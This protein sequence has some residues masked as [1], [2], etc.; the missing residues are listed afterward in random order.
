M[1]HNPNHVTGRCGTALF[2]LCLNL[3][4]ASL[5]MADDGQEPITRQHFQELDIEIQVLKKEVLKVNRDLQVLEEELL[6]PHGQQLEVFVSMVNDTS[7]MLKDVRLQLDGQPVVAHT[8][9]RGEEAALHEGGVHRLYVGGIREGQHTLKVVIAGTDPQGADFSRQESKTI[10]KM[11][12]TRYI[13]LR[14]HADPDGR[15][16][17]VSILEW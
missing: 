14:L 10:T 4:T 11:P 2:F 17:D 13:E 1:N 9:T 15:K 6:Y 8:Y 5:S 7:F 16:P 12:G 3:M